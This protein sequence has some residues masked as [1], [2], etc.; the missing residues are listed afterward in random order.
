MDAQKIS[1]RFE[2]V[3]VIPGNGHSPHTGCL[4]FWCYDALLDGYVTV[5]SSDGIKNIHR[6]IKE[7]YEFLKTLNHPGIIKVL[8]Y[9]KEE[10][11]EYMV[12]SGEHRGGGRR[13]RWQQLFIEF[14]ENMAKS[15]LKS[16]MQILIYLQ[17]N[18]VL[19]GDIECANMVYNSKINSP[20]LI[21]FGRAEYKK[22]SLE[23]LISQLRLGQVN[24]LNTFFREIT[25]SGGVYA[26][27]PQHF[28]FDIKPFI[29]E[30]INI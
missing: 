30:V 23:W 15:F 16:F 9:Y 21:D 26:I 8:D 22:Y 7:E 27:E 5:K 28:R 13:E 17:K 19:H 2:H 10:D 6:T 1:K 20:I 29:E 11:V 4:V 12:M 3:E 18:N 25:N 14:D 24:K